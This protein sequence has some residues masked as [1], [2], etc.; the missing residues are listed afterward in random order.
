MLHRLLNAEVSSESHYFST[1]RIQQGRAR[2][3][4]PGPRP[5]IQFFG[6]S[7]H[8]PATGFNLPQRRRVRLLAGARRFG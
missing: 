2:T 1:Q 5:S 6:K 3:L 4:D 8:T 7:K